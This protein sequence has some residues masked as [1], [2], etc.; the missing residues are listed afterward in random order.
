MTIAT[1]DKG[2]IRAHI[3]ASVRAVAPARVVVAGAGPFDLALA[4][5]EGGTP[6][7]RVYACDISLYSSAIGT[8]LSTGEALRVSMNHPSVAWLRP[9]AE[10]D[11]PSIRT[12]CTILALRYIEQTMGKHTR[13]KEANQ[14]EYQA[15]APAF[16]REINSRLLCLAERL[17]GIQYRIGDLRPVVAKTCRDAD[18]LVL[19]SPP[20][21]DATQKD[22][23][24]AKI[25]GV[26]QWRSPGV[27]S[28]D[29]AEDLP[30]VIDVLAHGDATALVRHTDDLQ[31]GDPADMYGEPWRS[32]MVETQRVPTGSLAH[33]LCCNKP[34]R[35][36]QSM[37]RKDGR[38]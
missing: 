7:D 9:Y 17:Q 1:A 10:V 26:I 32:V 6:A 38:A 34:D 4:A 12:A 3:T 25:A 37:T 20:H 8:F 30:A 35:V 18:A 13:L 2:S 24:A 29:P 5:V 16:L 31:W 28:L 27:G 23:A 14:R 33:W 21:V 36:P 15:Q 11:A 19:L 22:A